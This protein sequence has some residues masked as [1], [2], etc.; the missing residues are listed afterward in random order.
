MNK[1]GSFRGIFIV[2]IITII[3]A[4]LWNKVNFIRTFAET[5]LNPTV[6][7]LLNWN[8]TWG[9]TLII[10]IIAIFMTLVQKYA[11]DQKELTRMKKEQKEV[12]E[13]LKKMDR[14]SKEYQ[15][16]SMQS[17]SSMGPMMKL[18]MRP[19]IYTGIPFILLFRWF[20]DYFSAFESFRFFGFL[21]W[22]W[23]YLLG[24]IIFSSILRKIFKVV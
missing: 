21:S 20:M 11:T 15:E 14:T 3:I 7:T 23:F 4:S 10:L 19:I 24:S 13:K 6:G 5:I 12:G 17:I 18:S 2:M 1:E 8:L 22:F 16:L 9:M